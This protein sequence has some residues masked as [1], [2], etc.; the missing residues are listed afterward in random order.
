MSAKIR[1]INRRLGRLNREQAA[2]LRQLLLPVIEDESKHPSVR[3]SARRLVAEIARETASSKVWRFL[4]IS[5]DQNAAVIRYLRFESC[6]PIVAVDLWSVCL[7]WLDFE[8]GEVVRSREQLAAEVGVSA[9]VVSQVMGELV[10]C[11]AVSRLF[12]DDDGNRVR[13]VRYFVNP[14]V[15]T[16]LHGEARDAAQVA[17]PV[18]SVP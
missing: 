14:R 11:G 12:E 10:T 16:H 9:K 1:F 6:R 13:W 15:G 4:M 8:T 17:A 3:L 7:R 2:E 18:L 5:P